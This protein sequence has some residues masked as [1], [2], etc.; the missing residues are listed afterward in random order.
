MDGGSHGIGVRGWNKA[1]GTLVWA[2]NLDIKVSGGFWGSGVIGVVDVVMRVDGCMVRGRFEI[3][4]KKKRVDWGTFDYRELVDHTVDESRK[5]A[6]DEVL[7][8]FSCR[9]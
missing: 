5:K 6:W 7:L 3:K 8:M 4:K 2:V 1:R 9:E